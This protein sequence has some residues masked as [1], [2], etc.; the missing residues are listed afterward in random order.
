MSHDQDGGDETRK[1]ITELQL[2]KQ[3]TQFVVN[4]V[5]RDVCP[6]VVPFIWGCRILSVLLKCIFLW[7]INN[8]RNT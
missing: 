6:G 2:H 8:L 5:K 7:G 3:Y 1:T 4:M